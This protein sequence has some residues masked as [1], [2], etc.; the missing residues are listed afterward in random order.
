[1]GRDRQREWK[2]GERESW[3]GREWWKRDRERQIEGESE[4]DRERETKREI[5]REKDRERERKREKEREPY[6]RPTVSKMSVIQ[7]SEC[8]PEAC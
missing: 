5:F 8:H 3:M 2:R 6:W 1:V 4:I 7:R